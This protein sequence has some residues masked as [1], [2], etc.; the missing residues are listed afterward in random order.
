MTLLESFEIHSKPLAFFLN[1]MKEYID[2]MACYT[3]AE[4]E[5]IHENYTMFVRILEDMN[6]LEN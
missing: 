3:D 2:P 5:E 6:F 4:I 1:W